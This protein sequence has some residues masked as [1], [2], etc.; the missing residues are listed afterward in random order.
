MSLQLQKT[1]F[2]NL[3]RLLQTQKIIEGLIGSSLAKKI[4]LLVDLVLETKKKKIHDLTETSSITEK[5]ESLVKSSLVTEKIHGLVD[6]SLATGKNSRP[7]WGFFSRRKKF[8]GL[9]MSL[10]LQKTKFANLL[11]LLQ[12]QKIIEGL[13]ESSLAQ[14]IH[15]LVALFLATKK[16]FT[17]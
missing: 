13:V 16:K 10:Q 17:T 15:G 6:V 9:L 3:L 1:K 5:N 11:R 8:R 4:H 12:T 2:A 7:N 14:K